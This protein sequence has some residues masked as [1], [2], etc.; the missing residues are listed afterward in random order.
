MRRLVG[1]FLTFSLLFALASCHR[2]PEPEAPVVPEPEPL[3]PLGFYAD[4]FDADT[5]E[6][7]SG[8][9]FSGLMNR[10]GLG[11]RATYDMATAAATAR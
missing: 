7:R 5:M 9:T 4:R 3:P 6:V 10:L 8:E 1:G 11:A 2:N